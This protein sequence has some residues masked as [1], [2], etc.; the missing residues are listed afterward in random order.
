MC[1][2]VGQK[3]KTKRETTENEFTHCLVHLHLPVCE[4]PQ[5]LLH[6]RLLRVLEDSLLAECLVAESIRSLMCSGNGLLKLPM[7]ERTTH[8]HD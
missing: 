7:Q 4:L 2:D 5:Y 3:T 8:P 6:L 1:R